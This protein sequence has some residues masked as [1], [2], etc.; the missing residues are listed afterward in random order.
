M[1]S[2]WSLVSCYSRDLVE[3]CRMDSISTARSSWD[4]RR[5]VFLMAVTIF[6][7]AFLLFQVQPLISK[8][9]LPWF[10]GSPTVW[11]TAM[12]FFQCVLFAGYAYAHYVTRSIGAIPVS[13]LF[14]VEHRIVSCIA[15]FSIPLRA[16]SR[17]NS[18]CEGLDDFILGFRDR[19]WIRRVGDA[20][21]LSGRSGY[22]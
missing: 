19:L 13:S 12:L 17:P 3:Y 14:A 9:I 20:S 2:L 18:D 11:T 8:L 1:S 16:E 22:G 10:G 15:E 7:S 21:S 4:C 6:A 5:L